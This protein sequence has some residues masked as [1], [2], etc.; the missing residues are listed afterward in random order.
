MKRFYW[1]AR[2]EA[3]MPDGTLTS[4]EQVPYESAPVPGAHPDNLAAVATLFG[5]NPAPVENCRVLELGCATGG[6]LISIA[7]SVPGSRCLGIDLSP[8]HIAAGREVIRAA[9]LRNIE[10]RT[11]SILYIGPDWGEFD[12]II[13]HGVW[14]WVPPA[15]QDHILNV[16]ARNL[17]PH[18]VVY[19]SYN[20]YP[21]WH[22]AGM[23]RDMVNYH[24][25]RYPDPQTRVNEVRRFLDFLTKLVERDP[26]NALYHQLLSQQVEDLRESGDAYLFHEYLEEFNQP[27]Y[28]HQ[29]AER[30]SAAGLQFLSE[31][32]VSMMG[33][34]LSGEVKQSLHEW[35][36]DII[37][38]EQYLDFVRNRRFRRTLLCHAS[39]SINRTPE[40][41]AMRRFRFTTLAEAPREAADPTANAAEQFHGP[42]GRTWT[43][44]NPWLR[45]TVGLVSAATPRSL[46]FAELT[47]AVPHVLPEGVGPD[48][49]RLA[50]ALFQG[51][52][53][54]LFEAHV[55]EP[56]F[57]T[58]LSDWP[59]A[60][61][62]ARV[63][64]DKQHRAISR[65]HRMFDME[66][67][68]RQLLVALDGSRDRGA[69]IELMAQRV[70]AGVPLLDENN[71]PIRDP[72]L[73]EQ[74]LARGI[75]DVLRR[76]AR[77]ALL[78]G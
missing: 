31:V 1:G 78:V 21:G 17:A 3:T 27:V 49:Q 51:L 35:S 40:P 12:Y 61:L 55:F 28:F 62:L 9:E 13:C 38:Y 24:G 57:A 54:G 11:G 72:E 14:S 46:S 66:G 37:A 50:L 22:I 75:G 7:D 39:E 2:D 10:L 32:A 30:A 6:N 23:V 48:K 5:L 41:E 63:T 64:T 20:V 69:L 29:F 45:A 16:C 76:F 60:S 56:A 43:T 19:V 65:R 34:N 4:Y 73:V 71:E 70:R 8:S 33:G 67:L 74:Y 36:E 77:N 52:L 18:G 53:S 15:V 47:Q 59:V 26:D 58:E 68:P 42:K 44:N 25:R